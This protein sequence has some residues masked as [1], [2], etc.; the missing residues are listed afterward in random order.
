VYVITGATGN[1]GKPITLAL[2]MAGKRV[3]II[4]RDPAK[5]KELTNK[6]AELVV[7]SGLD[8]EVL[9]QSF[10]GATAVYAMVPVDWQTNDYTG[11]Q[12]R[13]ATAM[14]EALKSCKVQYVVSL[15]TQ[16]AHL[17]S[18]SGVALGLHKME[19]LFDG[20]EGLNT[21]HLRPTYFMENTLGL[22]GLVKQAGVLGT[23]TRPDLSFPVIATRDVAAYAAKR[24]LALDFK[25]H[26]VQDL[27]GA[28]DVTYPE[29]TAVYGKAIGKPDLK[30]VTF[31]YDDFKKSLIGGM[32]A[33]EDVADKFITFIQAMN[34]GNVMVA[35][36]TPQ[37]TTPTSIEDFAATFAAVYGVGQ[38]TI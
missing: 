37:N 21:L 17:A 14:A 29:M 35:T 33:S 18:N 13:Y 31:S 3:R 38:R 8:G 30:Y 5:A 12:V 23:P 2:L 4:S 36:R 7:G 27:L 16:G 34:A 9:K 6:G 1:T 25:G 28:R 24:L 22:I 15:S 10:A 26:N 32:G 11:H 20:I 19:K